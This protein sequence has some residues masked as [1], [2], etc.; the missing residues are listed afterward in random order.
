V[1]IMALELQA[2][3]NASLGASFPTSFPLTHCQG[4]ACFTFARLIPGT[5]VTVVGDSGH[6][7]GP[8][9][10]VAFNNTS[11]AVTLRE[12][13]PFTPGATTTTV[14]DCTKVESISF[15]S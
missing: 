7:Y 3:A 15:T 14:I 12:T 10:F 2:N 1:K 11:C 13:D 6:V 9:T 8:A 5:T 4:T